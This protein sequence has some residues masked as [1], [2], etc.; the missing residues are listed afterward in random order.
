M[1][2]PSRELASVSLIIKPDGWFISDATTKIHGITQ[3]IAENAGVPIV[4][5]LAVFTQLCRLANER[6]AFNIDFDQRIIA[7]G[8]AHIKKEDIS[9]N[10][11]SFC[12]MKAMAPL[13]KI[14][15]PDATRHYTPNDPWKLPKLAEAYQHAFH[16]HFHGAH[17][18]LADVKATADLYWWLNTPPP[19]PDLLL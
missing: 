3:D 19:Q 5:A 17:N 9:S 12:V 14:P 13:C 8:M 4:V 10:L 15:K 7:R 18:A 6:I 11:P 16:K 1:D 2:G